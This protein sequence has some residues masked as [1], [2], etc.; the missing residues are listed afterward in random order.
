MLN[1]R[2][3][4]MRVCLLGQ[5]VSELTMMTD[6]QRLGLLKS[7]SGAGIWDERRAESV[8]I[9]EDTST[10]KMR[11]EGLIADIEQKLKTLEDTGSLLILFW[12]CRVFHDTM[13]SCC[14][15]HAAWDQV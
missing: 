8:K 2:S 7:I 9:M 4:S 6:A 1:L 11:N 5:Q 13:P 3:E 12:P 14:C 10:R 15:V